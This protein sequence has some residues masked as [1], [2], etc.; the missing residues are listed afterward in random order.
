MFK[1][2]KRNCQFLKLAVLNKDN[3]GGKK[4]AQEDIY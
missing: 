4:V 3:D 2:L 1:L